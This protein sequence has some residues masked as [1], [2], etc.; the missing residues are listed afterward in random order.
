MGQKVKIVSWPYRDLSLGRESY[1]KLHIDAMV[2][3]GS[4]LKAI[5][6]L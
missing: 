5:D 1:D 6:R 4:G 2:L 3:G